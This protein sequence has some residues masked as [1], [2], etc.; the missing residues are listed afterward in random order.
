[1]T[2]SS[3]HSNGTNSTKKHIS[4]LGY[5]ISYPNSSV[6]TKHRVQSGKLYVTSLLLVIFILFSA[7]CSSLATRTKVLAKDRDF[8]VLRVGSDNASSLAHRYLG[9][10]DL[11]WVIEDANYPR[12]IAAGNEI[13]IPLKNSN[14]IGIEFNGY[15]T[16][17][18]LCYHRFDNSG[19]QLAV[20]PKQ[21]REQLTYLRDNGYRVIHLRELYS[22]L[23]GEQSLPKR[24]VVL[25]IDD[26][27]RS[28]FKI[29]YPILKEYEFPATVFIYS[30]YMNNGGLKTSELKA[31]KEGGL[32]SI[33][34]HS[35]THSNLA[36]KAINET[37][38]QYKKRVLE[39]VNAPSM[40]LKKV[41]GRAPI[42]YAYPF[43]DT[44]QQVIGELK[45]NGLLLGLTVQP[46]ANAAYT[47]P[48]L[49]SR[50]MVFGDRGMDDFISK[51]K[52]FYSR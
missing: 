50:S 20:T 31:M 15:Q 46:G 23:K 39:E 43:G 18:I 40:K 3:L 26:G 5:Q 12:P 4:S 11:G 42:F 44:N 34:S 9:D 47:Y 49:L 7:G 30:D 13:V 22:F 24:S 32:I 10:E 27:H 48:Y 52:T 36:V 37:K 25:T 16:V 41:L 45:A 2:L 14:P 35:K 17:P 33:Q 29:A 6:Q 21:F 51:L 19:E 8:V 28:I 1:M 38:K